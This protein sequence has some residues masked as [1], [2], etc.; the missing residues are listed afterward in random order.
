MYRYKGM[1]QFVLTVNN[2]RTYKV[3]E[4]SKIDII[5][6][7]KLT[8]SFTFPIE[9]NVVIVIKLSLDDID[10]NDGYYVMFL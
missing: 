10:R 9:Q 4:E 1:L 8:Q 5:L 3:H 2:E 7:N 6:P